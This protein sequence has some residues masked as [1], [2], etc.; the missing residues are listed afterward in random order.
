ML[1]INHR[2]NSL[3]DLQKLNPN[4]GAETD[5]RDS[6][7][8]LIISHDPYKRGNYFNSFLDNYHEK[9]YIEDRPTPC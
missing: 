2:V 4:N 6:G 5:V 1:I 8:R 7:K 9:I 3:T